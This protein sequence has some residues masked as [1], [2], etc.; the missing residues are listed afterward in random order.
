MLHKFLYFGHFC[1]QF[2]LSF[3]SN[4]LMFWITSN[5]FRSF[6]FTVHLTLGMYLV[7]TCYLKMTLLL[8]HNTGKLKTKEIENQ[9][10]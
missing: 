8:S 4:C 5:A 9:D 6:E 2:V 7:Q 10:L 3:F 1:L